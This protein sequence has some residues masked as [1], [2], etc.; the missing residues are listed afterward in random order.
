MNKKFINGLLLATLVVGSAGSFTSCKD[1]DDDIDNLQSQ[2]DGINVTIGQLQEL[3][4]SGKVIKDVT[5]NADGVVITM[6][7]GKT[8][9]ITNGKNG[10]NGADGKNAT[11][12][13]IN[14]DGYWCEDG[15]VTEWKAVGTDGKNGTDGTNGT[16]GT[17]GTN[18]TNGQNGEYYVP[19]V[20]T[21]C[22]DIYRDGEKIKSTDIKWRQE[23]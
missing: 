5:S 17:D 13:T 14:S 11:V 19:N 12:W 23:V 3:I 6:T 18:G 21:G 7:D 22:F 10:A 2:I 1:Y 9:T 20:E 4:S 8:Y 15:K 16:N